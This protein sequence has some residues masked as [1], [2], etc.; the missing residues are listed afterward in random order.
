MSNA[1]SATHRA[2]GAA[3][4]RFDDAG[5]CWPTRTRNVAREASGPRTCRASCNPRAASAR[6]AQLYG[7]AL[8]PEQRRHSCG[9]TVTTVSS[10]FARPTNLAAS[11]TAF[12]PLRVDSKSTRTHGVVSTVISRPSIEPL[13]G[14]D[15]MLT[16]TFVASGDHMHWTPRGQSTSHSRFGSW[17][18][19][20][21][22]SR[23]RGCPGR[24]FE[25]ANPPRPQQGRGRQR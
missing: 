2:T 16:S 19:V 5:S 6:T 4:C 1:C 13:R 3:N 7:S 8:G 22:P 14:L 21:P 18:R 20:R 11:R 17:P 9:A 15:S 25:S 23:G 24:G 10:P 12:T